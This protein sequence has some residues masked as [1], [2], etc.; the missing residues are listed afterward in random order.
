[1]ILLILTVLNG[2]IGIALFFGAL[3]G[4][5]LGFLYYNFNPAS[6][7]MGDSGSYFLGFCLAALS[8]EGSIKSNTAVAILIPV[9]AM[10]VP[11]L[12][13]IFAPLRRFLLG[14][15][16][17]SPDGEH[18]HHRLLQLGLSHRLAVMTMYGMTII[19]GIAALGLVHARD[20]RAALI[21]LAIAAVG[22]VSIRQLGYLE[23]IRGNNLAYWL[24][25]ISYEA[26]L[27]RERR[28]FISLQSELYEAEDLETLWEKLCIAFDYLHFDFAELVL[29][30][31]GAAE[32]VGAHRLVWQR[33]IDCNNPCDQE[34]L[35]QKD[36]LFKL[37]LPLT[38]RG[39]GIFGRL[40]L[41]KD[42]ERDPLGHYTIRRVEHLRRIVA[43]AV[44]KLGYG[45]EDCS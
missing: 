45:K 22:I 19:L 16:M 34:A 3:G 2:K 9:I 27:P 42:L 15:R 23:F 13:T 40:W 30:N 1:M 21:L 24:M 44:R 17:F 4:S 20:E 8:I 43:M 31:R 33:N 28:S 10:G 35:L 5:T 37:E 29:E 11:M 36:C 41:V 39:N 7:F 12:D 32:D 25:S 18:L 6:I 38:D 26:G 14:R